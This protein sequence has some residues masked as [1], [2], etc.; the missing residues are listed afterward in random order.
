M[1]ALG[2]QFDGYTLDE[3]VKNVPNFRHAGLMVGDPHED[4][5][6]NL[7]QV[8]I[9]QI[10]AHEGEDH[11]LV[12]DVFV[13]DPRVVRKMTESPDTVPPIVVDRTESGYRHI[14]GDNRVNAAAR[15]GIT[16]LP[17]YVRNKRERK[18]T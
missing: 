4:D 11:P 3:V 2:P 8:P 5:R 7:E 17:A 1:S 6:Y 12:R 10:Q 13:P 15:L 18:K 9:H 14:D 16:H